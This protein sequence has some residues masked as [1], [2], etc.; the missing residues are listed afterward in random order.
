MTDT[1]WYRY[2][3]NIAPA[4]AAFEAWGATPGELFRATADALLNVMVES[5]DSVAGTERR[6]VMA[7]ADTLDMAL[8]RFLDELVYL[9]DAEGL[10]LRLKDVTFGD[11]DGRVTVEAVARGERIDPGRHHLAVD[12]KAVTL[13]RFAVVED[14]GGWKATVVLDI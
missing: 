5:V 14:G 12:V 1:R 9:K 3:E 11:A 4:D 7:E 13:H 2:L 8:F 6:T 10:F